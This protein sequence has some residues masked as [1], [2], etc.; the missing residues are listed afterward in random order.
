MQVYI[1]ELMEP[2]LRCMHDLSAVHTLT[3]F[4][5]YERSATAGKVFWDLLPTY[6]AHRK[7]PEQ[8][9]GAR[10]HADNLGLFELTRIDGQ[11][12]Q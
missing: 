8:S 9:Y 6:F 10:P 7:I 3:L 5:Y 1:A 2:L 4:A 12:R 11:Y